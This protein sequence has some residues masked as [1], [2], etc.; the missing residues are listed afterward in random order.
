MYLVTDS[1]TC[2]T[3]R[4]LNDEKWALVLIYYSVLEKS[5]Q[6]LWN[7]WGSW[8][9]KQNSGFCQNLD[10]NIKNMLNHVDAN[11]T[12]K[13]YLKRSHSYSYSTFIRTTSTFPQQFHNRFHQTYQLYTLFWM[14]WSVDLFNIKLYSIEKKSL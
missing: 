2:P 6:G 1:S 10:C 11:C 14:C 8:S 12:N 3:V 13:T 7:K 4:A 9:F 5:M